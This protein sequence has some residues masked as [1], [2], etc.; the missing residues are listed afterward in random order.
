MENTIETPPSARRSV[1]LWITSE[2]ETLYTLIPEKQTPAG[3]ESAPLKQILNRK[4]GGGGRGGVKNKATPAVTSF[5]VI[6]R[7]Q[8]T[9]R[10]TEGVDGGWNNPESFKSSAQYSLSLSFKV[11]YNLI[12]RIKVIG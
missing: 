9:R 3:A 12:N 10:K 2:W 5:S 6:H 1:T 8:T 11:L 4:E 7:Y